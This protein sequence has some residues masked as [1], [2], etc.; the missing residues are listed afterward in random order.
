[1]KKFYVLEHYYEINDFDEA[2]LIGIYSSK[3]KAQRALESVE[4][5]PGFKD[6]PKEN[7]NID[8]YEID[9]DNWTEGFIHDL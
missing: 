7:F 1:M 8:C 5:L 6:F 2:K 9:E 3:E 4:N